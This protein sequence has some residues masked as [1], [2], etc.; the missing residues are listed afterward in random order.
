MCCI[1]AASNDPWR[2][3]RL[4][5]GLCH[6]GAAAVAWQDP[7]RDDLKKLRREPR[8]QC[9]MGVG[10]AWRDLEWLAQLTM[11]DCHWTICAVLPPLNQGYRLRPTRREG[12]KPSRREPS[13]AGGGGM[14]V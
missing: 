4:C 10:G 14:E 9:A 7:A 1:H 6:D 8:L 5:L 3:F 2:P 12:L 11:H 13:L